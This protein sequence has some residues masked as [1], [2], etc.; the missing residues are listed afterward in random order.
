ME[1]LF[2]MTFL[3]LFPFCLVAEEK[4]GAENPIQAAL[5]KGRKL[6][7]EEK[8]EEGVQHFILCIDLTEETKNA[9]FSPSYEALID[10]R[11]LGKKHPPAVEWMAAKRDASTVRF[12]EIAIDTGDLEESIPYRTKVHM[13]TLMNRHLE[14]PEVTVQL[15]KKIEEEFPRFAQFVDEFCSE[16]LI[17]EGEYDLVLKY[18]GDP[19]TKFDEFKEKYFRWEDLERRGKAGIFAGSNERNFISNIDRF[20]KVLYASGATERA[21]QLKAKAMKVV[22]SPTY[23]KPEENQESKP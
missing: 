12:F 3:A 22:D 6:V 4:E 9:R 10:W 23:F 5:D 19:E 20:L 21:D 13:I 18:L 7:L 17:A 1:F 2:R 8:Y 14:Q 16:A 15:F 11:D